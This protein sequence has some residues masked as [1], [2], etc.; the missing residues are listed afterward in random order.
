MEGYIVFIIIVVTAAL[1]FALGWAFRRI[2]VIT[3][4]DTFKPSTLRSPAQQ[5]QDAI[6]QL[7]NELMNTGALKR[8]TLPDGQEKV[9]LKVVL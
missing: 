4:S 7:K 2:D 3:I 6:M 1:F 9:S 5:I 8:E